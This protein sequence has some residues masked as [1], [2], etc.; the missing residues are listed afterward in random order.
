MN[1]NNY[2]FHQRGLLSNKP[3]AKTTD[4]AAKRG[5]LVFVGTRCAKPC[6]PFF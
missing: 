1:W 5:R 2:R 4:F 3:V 6:C